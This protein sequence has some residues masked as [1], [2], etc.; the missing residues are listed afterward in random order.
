MKKKA[1]A[2]VDWFD[3]VAAT[4]HLTYDNLL[5]LMRLV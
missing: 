5:G 4:A 2:E 3:V 1:N